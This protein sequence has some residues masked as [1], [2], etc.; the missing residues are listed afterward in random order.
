MTPVDEAP[1]RAGLSVPQADKA[2]FAKN[3]IRQ[4][5]CEL[6]FPTLYELEGAKPPPSFAHALRKEYPHQEVVNSISLSN[7][8]PDSA[9]NHLFRSKTKSWTVTLRAAAVV[10]ETNN[11]SSFQIFK[12]RLEFVVQAASKVIDSDFFTRVGLRYINSVPYERKEIGEWV[13][14]SLVAPLMEGVYGDPLEYAGRVIGTTENGGYILQHGIQT[15]TSRQRGIGPLGVGQGQNIHPSATIQNEYALD[16]DLYSEDV[17]LADVMDTVQRL[18]DLEY[19]LFNWA[20]GPAAKK[21]LGPSTLR[22]K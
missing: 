13:N 4:A 15:T 6:R 1:S 8:G 9:N 11:Y 21:H 20:I 10:L 2:L 18:H 14:P 16:F 7:S 3:F 12:D 5:V 19:S 22:G 17:E